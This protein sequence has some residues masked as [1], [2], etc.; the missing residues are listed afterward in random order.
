MKSQQGSVT[1]ET[2]TPTW[3]AHLISRSHQLS[4]NETHINDLNDGL[5][6]G[7]EVELPKD[8]MLNAGH[9]LVGRGSVCKFEYLRYT[10]VYIC[11]N[12]G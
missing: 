3:R 8:L 2:A 1:R 4:M 9:M 6:F 5:K 10:H 7:M 11:K 12:L